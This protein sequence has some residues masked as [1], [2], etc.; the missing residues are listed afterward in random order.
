MSLQMLFI[1]ALAICCGVA[2]WL[3]RDSERLTAAVLVLA[4]MVSPLVQ[5]SDF[6]HPEGGI[7]SID[8]LLLVYLL[9]L[10][11]RSDRYWPLWAAGFQ[12]V[13]TFIH[14][15]R[16]VDATVWPYAYAT[17]QVFWS[18]PVLFALAA[19]TWLEARYRGREIHPFP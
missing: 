3:G 9:A 10:A 4:A 6:F 13:G 12:V 8:V 2:F 1:F 5:T 16:L 11:L 15:A 14:V 18:Y 19:G 17:A 7:L